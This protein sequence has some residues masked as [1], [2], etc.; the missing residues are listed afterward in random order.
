MK[1]EYKRIFNEIRNG[2]APEVYTVN[3]EIDLCLFLQPAFDFQMFDEKD[4]EDE[5]YEAAAEWCK[6]NGLKQ[7]TVEK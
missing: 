7:S 6:E 4:D 5:I 1:A 2:V 3:G